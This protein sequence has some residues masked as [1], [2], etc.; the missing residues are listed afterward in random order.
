MQMGAGAAGVD[1]IY[2]SIALSLHWR[3]TMVKQNLVLWWTA[4]GFETA[5][6][7]RRVAPHFLEA[8]ELPAGTG[9]LVAGG[10]R[11]RNYSES[12]SCCTHA[13]CQKEA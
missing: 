5:S 12:G 13:A 2:L 9:G 1:R 8:F 10:R 7:K 11:S 3:V 6:E 4:A